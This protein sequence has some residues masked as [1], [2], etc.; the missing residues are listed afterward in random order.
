MMVIHRCFGPLHS[1]TTKS[2]GCCLR[3]A[4]D[5]NAKDD[6]DI[7]PLFW[8]A[9]FR[10]ESVIGLLLEHSA[11]P[12]AKN[13]EGDMPLFLATIEGDKAIVQQLQQRP[14]DIYPTPARAVNSI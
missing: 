4:G 10:R 7:T 11:D 5:I 3:T 1:V 14:R 12:R 8:A 9:M 6:G 2:Y 13:A